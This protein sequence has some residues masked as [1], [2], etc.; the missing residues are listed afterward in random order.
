MIRI[1]SMTPADLALGMRLSGQAG[2]NQTEADWRRLLALG[3][4][5][6][7]VAEWAG[8]P[9]G[10]TVTCIFEAIAWIAAVLVDEALRRRGIGAALVEHALKY[11]DGRGAT[12]AR[13][14]ATPLGRP[15]YERLG[16]AAEYELVRMQ[17]VAQARGTG[18]PGAR[19]PSMSSARSSPWTAMPPAP[20]VGIFWST[21]R[22]GSPGP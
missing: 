15:V 2:W 5:G 22:P 11:L 7:F 20:H 6:C 14:D 8:H 21:S 19:P 17:G 9:A 4:E 3:G 16:F 18:M 13:L 1:R 10:T 12:I